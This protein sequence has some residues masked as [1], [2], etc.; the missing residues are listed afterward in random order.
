MTQ[1][2][3]A[4]EITWQSQDLSFP[5]GTELWAVVCCFFFLL[6]AFVPTHRKGPRLWRQKESHVL[7]GACS[8]VF[9]LALHCKASL[10]SLAVPM[11]ILF[12]YSSACYPNLIILRA[13]LQES[14]NIWTLFLQ[15]LV[16]CTL[17]MLTK[18][19]LQI[20]LNLQCSGSTMSCQPHNAS[21]ATLQCCL[22]L[23]S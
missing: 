2:G 9:F 8:D 14:C 22:V 18:L 6:E 21:K 15:L 5:C 4:A 3:S 19:L 12:L 7:F 20:S 23:V 13:F 16:S 1:A 17:Q 10:F 11:L